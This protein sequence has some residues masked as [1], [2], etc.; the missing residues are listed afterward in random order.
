MDSDSSGR[1]WRRI[2]YTAAA[3]VVFL[4]I[5]I[6]NFPYS[7]TFSSILAPKGLKLDYQGQ[8][9]S[10]PF[11]ATLD[12]VQLRHLDPAGGALIVDS[13]KVTLAPFFRSLFSGRPG[14]RIRAEL[15]NGT[16]LATVTRL[17]AQ[18]NVIFDAKDLDLARLR[19]QSPVNLGGS[20]SGKGWMEV[21]GAPLAGSGQLDLLGKALVLQLAPMFPALHLDRLT[22]AVRM[23]RGV[24]DIDRLEGQG[25]EMSLL[26]KGTIRLASTLP[27]STI[28]LS[29]TLNPTPEGSQRF[30]SLLSFLPHPPDLG[31]YT[32]RGPL[33]LPLIR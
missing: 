29:V 15:Y 24:V 18:T 14:V 21:N 32:V 22:G 8:H 26:A 5:L 7:Y 17:G 33:M 19:E 13:R 1:F 27:E 10:F 3:V 25:A 2:C 30:A 11:G 31:P 16:I 12:N 20:I 23:N 6:A 4:A 28:D 9:W